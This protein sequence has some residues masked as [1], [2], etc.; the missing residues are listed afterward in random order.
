MYS[1]SRAAR[2]ALEEIEE[3]RGDV[4]P[5]AVEVQIRDEQR[6]HGVRGSLHFLDRG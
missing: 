5:R 1:A 3:L 6:G 4:R 2:L